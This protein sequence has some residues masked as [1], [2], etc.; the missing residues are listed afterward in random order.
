MAGDR[1]REHCGLVFY[2]AEDL[3]DGHRVGVV[4][5]YRSKVSFMGPSVSMLPLAL[6]CYSG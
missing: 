2:P 4:F 5:I 3:N 6:L 1:E